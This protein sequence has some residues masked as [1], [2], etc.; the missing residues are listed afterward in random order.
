MEGH[1]FTQINPFFFLSYFEMVLIQR[2]FVQE[3]GSNPPTLE[4]KKRKKRFNQVT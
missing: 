3:S 2:S 1:F 4:R